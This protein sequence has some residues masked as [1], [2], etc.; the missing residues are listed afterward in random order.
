MYW[1][2]ISDIS[3]EIPVDPIDFEEL[4]LKLD[5]SLKFELFFSEISMRRC[6]YDLKIDKK[7]LV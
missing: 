2:Q 7:A 6:V 1:R 5:F 3:S 4:K